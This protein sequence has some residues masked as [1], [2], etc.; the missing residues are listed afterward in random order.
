MRLNST[1]KNPCGPLAGIRD[2]DRRPCE[3]FSKASVTQLVVSARAAS[4]SHHEWP[5]GAD[6]RSA[7]SMYFPDTFC[8]KSWRQLALLAN[9]CAMISLSVNKRV[10]FV[11][12][13]RAAGRSTQ[14]KGIDRSNLS[15]RTIL[16]LFVLLGAPMA[17][18]AATLEDFARDMARKVGATLPPQE[19]VSVD[20]HN[21]ST[22]TPKEVDRVSQA[23]SG[24]LR[25]SGFNLDHGGA[26]HVSV[27]LSEN[28]KGFLWSAE[29]SRGGTLRVVL[30]AVP[31]NLGDRPVS[32]SMPIL[33]RGEKFWEGPEKILDATEL[34]NSNDAGTLLLL[35]TDGLII[36]K[37]GADSSFKVE[38][39]A[40]QVATRSPSGTVQG[41]NSC[42]LL[43]FSPCVVVILN[44]H[45]CTIAL[46]TRTV[47]E[48]HV[49]DMPSGRDFP[50]IPNL[51]VSR[52]F[53]RS[54]SEFTEMSGRC[55]TQVRFATGAGDYT[56]PDSVQAFEE[57]WSTFDLLSDELSFP[58]PVM[59]LHVT[60]RIPTAIV[61]NL[62][63]GNYEAYRISIT[64]GG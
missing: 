35:E 15:Y 40:A 16:I 22:L 14:M 39:P 24:G 20:I 3:G 62:Q 61:R 50:Y 57:Q 10:E 21:L 31:R 43:E 47:G 36:H 27:M 29:I 37:K 64:C 46:Q 5:R 54:R 6:V 63:T 12:V 44:W 4:Q 49:E 53:P 45:V 56:Q 7:H 58:G 38:I 52:T 18:R 2:R 41:E 28:V 48:C 19:D 34:T 60:D 17:A 30:T 9:G 51:F 42:R 11:F 1:G 55:G 59:A 13:P 26:T 33:L 8:A 25:D 23:F 32:N